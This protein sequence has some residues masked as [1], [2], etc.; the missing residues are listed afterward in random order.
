M[1]EH[2]SDWHCF[3]FSHEDIDPGDSNHWTLG[4]HLHYVSHL[5]PN[6]NKASV[7]K[8]FNKRSTEIS[9]NLHIR[10]EPFHFPHPNEGTESD[11]N[12]KIT[13]PPWSIIF[14]PNTAN[15]C[16][17]APLPVAQVATRGLFIGKASLRNRGRKRR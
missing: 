8:Y 6:L 16:G 9:G 3:Y 11:F 15:G 10:F 5:W 13:L 4:C 2:G 14:D 12:D 17:S 1:F 7:L